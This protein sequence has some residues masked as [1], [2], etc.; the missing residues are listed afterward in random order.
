MAAHLDRRDHRRHRCGPRPRALRRQSPWRRQF[1]L[2][3]ERRYCRSRRIR[4][5]H[6]DHGTAGKCAGALQ[7]LEEY[8][9]SS[10]HPQDLLGNNEF[11]A[12]VANLAAPDVQL[13]QVVNYCLGANER[14][15]ALGA[16]ALARRTDSAP[17]VVRVASHLHNSNVWIAFFILRFLQARADRPVIGLT[18][19]QARPWWGRHPLFPKIFSDFIDARL[20]QGEK[21][22]LKEA[23]EATEDLDPDAVLVFLN[24]LTTSSAASLRETFEDWRRTRVDKTFLQ[25]IGR[26]WD[27]AD[28]GTVVVEH[29]ML[30]AAV[31][32]CLQALEHDPPQSFL[33]SGESGTGKDRAVPSAGGAS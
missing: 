9:D 19:A 23:L 22:Q 8:Y 27:E 28:D 1:H 21:P 32:L 30:S 26:I 7:E 15:A 11:E 18:L 16:E 2:S 10:A 24:A 6:G 20:A 4:T 29:P 17:A 5:A 33:I 13:E 14:L 25:S 31:K 3:R 12:G